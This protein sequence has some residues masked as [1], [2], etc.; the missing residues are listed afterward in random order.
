M[1]I[2]SQKVVTFEYTLKNS[3]GEVIE[4]SDGG[5]PHTYLHGAQEIIPG[6]ERAME[7]LSAGDERDVVVEP[8]DAYGEHEEEGVFAVP[9]AA[10]PGDVKVAVGDTLMGE[11]DEGNPV[12][13]HVVELRED[14][15][16]V[17]ANHPLAGERLHYHIAVRDVRDATAEELEH[18][19]SHGPGDEHHEHDEEEED[20]DEEKE[21]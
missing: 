9:R 13:V 3:D 15:I 1:L 18:G 14:A 6:L 17:D 4:T 11:D 19:H 21:G 2:T 10:F 16:I 8:A 20:E 5:E 7:G 12:P